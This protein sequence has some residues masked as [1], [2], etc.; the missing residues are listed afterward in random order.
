MIK[1]R[2]GA[3]VIEISRPIF[4]MYMYIYIKTYIYVLYI[5]TFSWEA[6]DFL[7]ASRSHTVC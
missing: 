4:Y 1:R 6:V 7:A 5:Y 2:V 3:K